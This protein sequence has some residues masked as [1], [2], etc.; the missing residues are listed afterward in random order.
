MKKIML[1]VFSLFLL[2]TLTGCSIEFQKYPLHSD[3]LVRI[4]LVDGDSKKSVY[5]SNENENTVE[6]PIRK[7]VS[8]VG[9]FD[10]VDGGNCYINARGYMGYYTLDDV[11]RTLYAR[12]TSLGNDSQTFKI[13]NFNIDSENPAD[14]NKT[15]VFTNEDFS[16][17]NYSSMII[18]YSFSL[19]EN[20]DNFTKYSFCIVDDSDTKLCDDIVLNENDSTTDNSN[21]YYAGQIQ[22]SNKT[23][24]LGYKFERL[25]KSVGTDHVRNFVVIIEYV[26]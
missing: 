20:Q 16:T 26:A 23:N 12:Y 7:N 25:E 8:F 17:K 4:T 18:Y 5:L 3:E 15:K 21:S 22:I 11:P 2:F 6:P 14:S 24:A 13:D 1:G 10:S 19:Q 9:Y